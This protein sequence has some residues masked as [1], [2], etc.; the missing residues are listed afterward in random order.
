MTL[1]AQAL[2]GAPGGSAQRATPARPGQDAA[3]AALPSG[4][5]EPKR[6]GE[7]LVDAGLATPAQVQEALR[8]QAQLD[9]YVPLGHILVAQNVVTRR[10]LLRIMERNRRSAPLG[11]LL[12]KSGLIGAKELADALREQRRTG[13]PLGH[14][15]VAANRITEHQLRTTLCMQLHI[16]FFDLD[17]IMID[18][19][20]RTLVNPKFAVKHQ[21]VPLARVA[22]TLVV[23]MDDPTQAFVVDELE[24]GTGLHVEIVTGTSAGIARA[25]ARLYTDEIRPRLGVGENVEVIAEDKRARDPRHD[26][27]P[28]AETLD[29]ADDIVRK[30]IRV[31]V[32]RGASDIHF[33]MVGDRLKV[34]FR[35]DGSLL[36]LNLGP[37]DD[38]ISRRRRELVARIKILSKLDIAEHRRPQD[39]S[40]RARVESDGR[41]VPFDFRV[42][43]IPSHYGE[44]AVIRV[45]DPRSAPDSLEAV[46]LSDAVT[47]GLRR[48]IRA[49]TGIILVTGPTGSGKS[50]TLF[51]LLRSI[52][53]PGIK[54]VTAENPIEYVCDGFSQHEVNE[55]IGNTF[56]GYLRSFLRHDPEVIMVGEIR[57]QETAQLAFRAAQTGHLV[58]STLHTNDAVS[59]ITRLRDLGVDTN[60]CTSSLL[61][62]VA[63]RLVR[64]VCWNCKEPYTPAADLLHEVFGPSPPALNW[65]RGAGCPACHY[66][67]YKRRLPLAELW[68]PSQH[69]VALINLNASFDEIAASAEKSTLS[70]AED[71]IAR[72]RQGRT[73]LDELVRALPHS[74]LRQL[75]LMPI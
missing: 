2:P 23:A 52:Y 57:D 1:A 8:L 9:R 13:R 72:L 36:S 18:P 61:G 22:D 67:G 66:S 62:V 64:E 39:G 70:M 21:L 53:R 5:A 40:F 32:D 55:R 37:L 59:A 19:G 20:L 54:I 33:E 3:P 56:A 31:A 71:A 58:L 26:H 24:R 63:Q 34:R 73:S 46:G 14:T 69:D 50:T 4:T 35:I 45:L 38:A 16:K 17:E 48:L 29:S 41:I 6:L 25:L 43:V 65:Y 7:L 10:Q 75:Q 44:N 12:V 15:L 49:T 47:A 30:L 60:V 11:E 68:T 42:S 27:L 74:T 51:G 28:P